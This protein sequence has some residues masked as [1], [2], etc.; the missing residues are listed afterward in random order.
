MGERRVKSI[1]LRLICG[2]QG[3]MPLGDRSPL[4]N[5]LLLIM[6]RRC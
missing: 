1:F 5:M 3:V 2:E 6:F 4:L